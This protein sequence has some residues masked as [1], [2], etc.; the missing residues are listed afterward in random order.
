MGGSE[1]L[2]TLFVIII[3]V[4]YGILSNRFGYKLF[5]ETY[6]GVL[7]KQLSSGGALMGLE[8]GDRYSLVHLFANDR[9]VVLNQIT[10]VNAARWSTIDIREGDGGTFHVGWLEPDLKT[11]RYAHIDASSEKCSISV[12]GYRLK[13]E[14][15]V[16]S[17]SKNTA[18]ICIYRTLVNKSVSLWRTGNVERIILALRFARQ[19]NS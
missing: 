14:I 8:V 6:P 12:A 4:F 19:P 11:L 15:K 3:I 9:E 5:Q 17:R 16:P 13:E 18:A 1:T 7:I 10:G 2:K